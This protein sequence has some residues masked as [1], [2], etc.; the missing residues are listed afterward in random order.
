MKKLSVLLSLVLCGCAGTF[1]ADKHSTTVF[2]LGFAAVHTR[3][4]DLDTTSNNFTKPTSTSA[5][6]AGKPK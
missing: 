6:E 2:C 3:S 1:R 4:V 5:G